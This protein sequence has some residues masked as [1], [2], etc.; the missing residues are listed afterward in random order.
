[1]A[2]GGHSAPA[3]FEKVSKMNKDQITQEPALLADG[4]QAGV[5][6]APAG[7]DQT[8]ALAQIMDL[9]A[10]GGPVVA[11]LMILSVF[12]LALIVAKLWQFRAMRYSDRASVEYAL[13]LHRGG[14][15]ATALSALGKCRSPVARA[16][17]QALSGSLRQDVPEHLVRE[18]VTRV[19]TGEIEDMRSFLRPLEVIAAVAPLLGLFGTVLGMID[20]FQQLEAAGNNVNPAVLSGGIWEA[21][22]TTAVGLAVAIPVVMILNWFERK[23]ERTGH[24]MDDVLT[25]AFTRD[26]SAEASAADPAAESRV[27]N[28]G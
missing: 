22:L 7:I 15:T 11:I 10:A 18:E 5:D 13:R 9:F 24:V 16:L 27:L 21:L 2:P 6:G 23:V 19:A 20:A 28:A 1:M 12:A 4:A 17:S 14:R 8:G 3:F 25:R 26:L